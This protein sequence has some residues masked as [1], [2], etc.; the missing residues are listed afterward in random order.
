[1]KASQ[2]RAVVGK[3]DGLGICRL[4]KNLADKP[5]E[6][7]ISIGSEEYYDATCLLRNIPCYLTRKSLG[8]C[9]GFRDHRYT[10]SL[11]T[12]TNLLC[13]LPKCLIKFS[14]RPLK[15]TVANELQS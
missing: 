3:I 9:K 7:Q 4:C 8:E 11:Q 14:W 10:T 15:E 2:G 5:S 13:S 12:I 6:E 1:M